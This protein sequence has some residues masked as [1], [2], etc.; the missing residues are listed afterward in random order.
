MLEPTGEVAEGVPDCDFW[1]YVTT[2]MPLFNQVFDF[3]PQLNAV[4]SAMTVV[5]VELVVLGRI[6]LCRVLPHLRGPSQESLVLHL[7]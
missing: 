7:S 4:I 1:G 5:F 2:Q 3:F 6:S